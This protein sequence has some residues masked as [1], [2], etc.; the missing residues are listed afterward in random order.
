MKIPVFVGDLC[1]APAEALCTSTNPQLSLKMGTGGSVRSRGGYEILRQCEAILDAEW[2]RSGERGMPL[3][4]AHPTTAGALPSKV[5]IH[6]V[7]SDASHRSSAAIIREC[8]KHALALA[9]AAGCERIA[10]PVFGT[11]HA[12]FR[13]E[14][15]VRAIAETLREA[16]TTVR[17]VF[18]VVNEVDRADA[19][20]QILRAANPDADVALQQGPASEQPATMWA[21]QW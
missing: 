17:C 4:S 21:A 11:G 7:A 9:D 12:R 18:V 8:V 10:M 13:F 5:I 1:D 3:G 2:R 14:D 15:A 16:K 6:C 19:A 20:L